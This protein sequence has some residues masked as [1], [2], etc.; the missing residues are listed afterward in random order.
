MF[1]CAKLKWK[2]VKLTHNSTPE[3]MMNKWKIL[4]WKILG[5]IF[6][7]KIFTPEKYSPLKRFPPKIY[8]PLWKIHL[9]KVYT[10]EKI[11]TLE[12]GMIIRSKRRLAGSSKTGKLLESSRKEGHQSA[13]ANISDAPK[14]NIHPQKNS[15]TKQQEKRPLIRSGQH[16]WCP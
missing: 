13:V 6:F 1:H 5:W 16:Q 15:P 10:S 8:S 9:W 3:V 7:R 14:K 2:N 11:F 4:R 12:F